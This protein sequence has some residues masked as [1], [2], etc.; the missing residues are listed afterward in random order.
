MRNRY[1]RYAIFTLILSY[2]LSCSLAPRYERPDVKYIGE[3]EKGQATNVEAEWKNYFIDKQLNELIQ[4]AL[5]SNKSIQVLGK[6]V[7]QARAMYGIKKAQQLPTLG[8][9]GS[10]VRTRISDNY[11]QSPYI[12]NYLTSYQA[13][14]GIS[15]WELD[16][17]GKLKSLKKVALE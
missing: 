16:F 4:K 15:S 1:L 5:S 13:T 12:P 14:L 10:L 7:E 11:S 9:T 3:F 17:W 2:L 6:Q 8:A